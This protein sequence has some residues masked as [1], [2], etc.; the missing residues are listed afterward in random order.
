MK[1]PF[2]YTIRSLFARRLTMA[3]TVL[4]VTLVAFVFAA[5]LMMANGLR[6][7]L[8]SS[9]SDNNVVVIRQASTSEIN[10][11]VSREQA[12]VIQTLPEIAVNENNQPLVVGEVIVIINESIKG[13]NNEGNLMVR[14]IEPLSMQVHKGVKIS[15]GRMLEFGKTEVI[16]GRKTSERY[17]SC[18]LGEILTFGMTDWTVVGIFEA[19]GSSF[20]SEV[21][22]DVNQLMPVF[23]RPVYSSMT[24]TMTNPSAF[25]QM[26]VRVTSD[27]R[28]TVDMKLEKQYYADQSTTLGSFISILGTIISIVFSLGAIIGAMITMYAAVANRTTEI[29]TMRALGFK[30]RSILTAFLIE[31][32]TISLIGGIL[33]LVAA[34]F[35]NAVSISTINWDTF[36]DLSFGFVISGD[37][38][39][40]VMIFA[41]AMGLIGGFFP[42]VRASRLKIVD[43]LRAE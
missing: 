40:E 42:A 27:P 23:G 13:T 2:K 24:F 34:S 30:R 39:I 1:V 12:S 15:A 37:I 11:F 32:I 18:D 33:G 29:A 31:A 25:E 20:E 41:L 9:G 10:S 3:L 19:E 6:E 14:G 17:V 38:I 21:W 8:V 35:L 28:M 16:I 22:G 43:A 26:R 7:A 5:V 36:S 4:G